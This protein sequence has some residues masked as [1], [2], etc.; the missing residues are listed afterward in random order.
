LRE[1]SQSF[2]FRLNYVEHSY[3]EITRSD[4]RYDLT[5]YRVARQLYD[6]RKPMRQYSLAS[7]VVLHVV[8]AK[9]GRRVLSLNHIQKVELRTLLDKS[10][11]ISGWEC[12]R[13]RL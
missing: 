4:V 12:I 1:D 11:E 5:R 7:M 9:H 6:V 13:P 10:A 3:S 2:S 8:F